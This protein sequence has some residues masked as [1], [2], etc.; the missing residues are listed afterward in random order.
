MRRLFLT[1]SLVAGLSGA[2][3]PAVLLADPGGPNLQQPVTLTC[4]DGRPPVTVNPGTATNQGRVAWVVN[5]NSVFVTA[6]LAFSD[7]TDTFVLFD[8]KP[9]LKNLITCTGDAGGGFTVIARGFF[10]PRR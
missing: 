5:S 9:G 4:S 6:Y 2:L 7:G 8:S 1:V 3:L 10:T